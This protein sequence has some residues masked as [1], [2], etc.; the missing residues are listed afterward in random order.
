MKFYQKHRKMSTWITAFIF[1]AAVILFKQLITAMPVLFAFLGKIFGVLSPFV[2]GFV[3]AFLLYVPCNKFEKLLKKAKRP[4]W[5][6]KHARG[7][8]VLIVYILCIALIAVLLILILPL[9]F[10]TIIKLYNSRNDY[11]ETVKHF[12]LSKCDS[13]GKLF[14]ID[15]GSMIENINPANYL[16]DINLSHLESI[17]NGVY[18]F[19]SAII[20]ALLTVFSS[21]YMLISRETLIRLI[22]RF[23]T[24]FVKRSKVKTAYNY[25][26]KIA[27]IFYSY[28]YSALLDATMLATIFST[29]FLIIGVDYAP[30]FGIAVGFANLIP[31]FGSIIVGVCVS[32]FVAITDGILRALIVVAC[33]LVIQQLDCNVIEPKIIGKNVGIHPLF[34]LIAI[35]IG[36]WVIGFWGL[37]V[38]VPIAATLGMIINDIINW[39]D[40]RISK[41]VIADETADSGSDGKAESEN[42]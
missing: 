13:E 18:K 40:R 38:S 11:Y 41:K 2:I 15:I 3:I 33:I 34:T 36:D 1:A 21:V 39:N 26:C 17:A 4:L 28:A 37:I 8:S 20:E 22:G 5:L 14:G 31:Y 25:L 23:L 30:F 35:T 7:I 42:G 6:S 29:A 12:V 19:G 32:V 16:D 10:K 27:N 9:I 24:L